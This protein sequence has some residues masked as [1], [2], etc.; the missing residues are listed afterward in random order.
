MQGN[1]SNPIWNMVGNL[2]FTEGFPN[3]YLLSY[4]DTMYGFGA[5]I[6]SLVNGKAFRPRCDSLKQ[7]A[8]RGAG[9]DCPAYSTYINTTYMDGTT[10][11]IQPNGI[12]KWFYGS[13]RGPLSDN[14]L[15]VFLS[16]PK[17]YPSK[18]TQGQASQASPRTSRSSF[19]QSQQL[20]T[21]TTRPHMSFG[22]MVP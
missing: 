17:I 20:E 18:D 15:Q 13:A 4:F 10:R 7:E 5:S 11:N 3:A 8:H 12:C 21:T 16:T 2:V 9:Y 6:V 14:F 1:R 22:W 19:A